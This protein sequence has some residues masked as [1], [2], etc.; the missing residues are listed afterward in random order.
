MTPKSYKYRHKILHILAEKRKTEDPKNLNLDRI[1]MS[2]KSISNKSGIPLN[3]VD[4]QLDVLYKTG[5]IE[6]NYK[7][8][9]NDFFITDT[10]YSTLASKSLLNDG[11]L[12][13]SQLFN[14]F[15]S[16][17]MQIIVAVIA[18]ITI[19]ANYTTVERLTLKQED[20]SEQVQKLSLQIERH[21]A[22][23]QSLVDPTLLIYKSYEQLNPQNQNN[24]YPNNKLIKNVR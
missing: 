4:A 8:P 12:L 9:S 7:D 14:N 20:L 24:S 11:L 5:D 21:Q 13:R 16:G 2:P 19:I 23:T 22:K 15:A 3:I 18:L 6:P 17:A 10:G 1:S